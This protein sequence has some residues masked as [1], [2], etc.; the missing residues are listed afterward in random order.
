ML[1]PEE[2]KKT[3][4]GYLNQETNTFYRNQTTMEEE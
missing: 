3:N 2:E 1:T 4:A